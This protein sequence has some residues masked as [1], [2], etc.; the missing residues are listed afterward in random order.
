MEKNVLITV[1]SVMDDAKGNNDKLSFITEGKLVREN[2]GYTLSYEESEVTGL[3]GTT[4]TLK[5]TKDSVTLF[6]QGS[7]ESIMLFEVGKTHITDYNTQ[8]GNMMMGITARN[9]DVNIKDSGGS[10]KVDYD[11]EYN[12][13]YGG[14]N[15]LSVNVIELNN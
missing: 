9:V 6:R 4:T 13:A 15:S 8:Y 5:L 12:S 2:D 11:L 10:I 7:V 1:E 3:N 14:R